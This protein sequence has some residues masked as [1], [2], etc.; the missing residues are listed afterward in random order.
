MPETLTK[1]VLTAEDVMADPKLQIAYLA[2]MG[3][4][5]FRYFC[6]ELLGFHDMNKEHDALCEYL[7]FDPAPVRMILLPRGTFK[8]SICTV[9]DTLHGLA[10]DPNARVLLYS[11]ATEKAE[12]FLTGIKHHIQ[13]AIQG[14]VWR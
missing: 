14:R 12:G 1:P 11:D 13:G 9:G 7:Q 5:S 6:R 8:S 4:Q 10:N 2:E 3:R